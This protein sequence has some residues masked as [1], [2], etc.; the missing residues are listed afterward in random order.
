[1]GRLP[2]FFGNICRLHRESH[3]FVFESDAGNSGF[4]EYRTPR[5]VRV[6]LQRGSPPSEEEVSYAVTAADSLPLHSLYEKSESGCT[7]LSVPGG[8]QTR[9]YEA[10]AR[11]EFCTPEGRLFNADG[12]SATW[13]GTEACVYKVLQPGERFVGMGEKSGP[14][15]RRGHAYTH[16]NTDKF[17]YPADHDPLYLSTPFYIGIH[18]GLLYGIFLDNSHRSTFNFGASTHR[19]AWFSVED[20][21]LDY[22]MFWGETIG[23]LL[24][25]YT[26][27]TGRPAL[28]PRWA[29]GFQ[30]CRYSYYPESELYALARTFRDKQLPCDVLY[31]DI[32]YMNAYKAFSFDPERFPDP[33]RLVSDLQGEG[34]KTAVILDPG[35]KIEKRYAAYESGK[36]RDVFVRYADGEPYV[37]E[38]WPGA[39]HFPD[40]TSER[41]RQWWSE[42]MRFYTNLGIRG[43]WNDM[44]EPAAWGQ[45]LPN[46][47]LFDNEGRGATHRQVR[48]V[49]G[50]LMTRSTLQGV[51][52]AAPNRRPLMLTRAGFSGIQRYSAVWTGDNVSSDEH[53]L[54]GVRLVNSLG[55]VGVA[56]SGNDAGGFAGE[57]SPSLYARWLS[58]AVFQPFLRAHTVVNSRDA[59][60]W[61]FGEEVEQI[62]RNYLNLRYRLVV[63]YLYALLRK[64]ALN[65]SSPVRSLAYAWPHRAEVYAPEYHNQFMLGDALL[66]VP[67]A[68]QAE[69]VRLWLPPGTWYCLWTGERIEGGRSLITECPT[70]KLPVFVRAGSV[71]P[72]QPLCQNLDQL[73]EELELH[74]YCGDS[75]GLSWYEDDGESYDFEQG[76]FS[77]RNITLSDNTLRIEAAQGDFVSSIKRWVLIWHGASPER[78]R[79]DGREYQT[80]TL[81]EHRLLQPITGIDSFFGG[82]GV[83]LRETNL[84][85]LSIKTVRHDL[86][87]RW[88]D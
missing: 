51:R 75:G 38:V 44:N 20:G 65:G 88:E 59:E 9:L 70:A 24:D 82:K 18:G 73:P 37:G 19:F 48:N 81:P 83:E 14:L 69:F 32:H 17:G 86:E 15:D 40:F 36:E 52:A 56:F 57:A 74:L 66:V 58:I 47:L 78:V 79:I 16:W 23:D 60:P 4:I 5:T 30:Q 87:I 6:L 10:G 25:E 1:M 63:P 53:L 46:A 2:E 76:I 33:K 43:F 13:I 50:M 42:L 77:E 85:R 62:A 55:L 35:I 31:L 41:G 84:R 54:L 80:E 71:L 8:I 7:V 27:L 72:M 67:A 21:A 61:C 22:Y 45:C 3:R 68:S 64:A 39:C 26:R 29:L 49:Y 28:P 34:F 11:L 12:M